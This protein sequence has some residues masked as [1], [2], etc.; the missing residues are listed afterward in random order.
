MRALL[1]PDATSWIART[2]S[3]LL[4]FLAS[5]AAAYLS[6]IFAVFVTPPLSAPALEHLV[7]VQEA[8]L[9]AP[10][11]APTSFWFELRSELEAQLIALAVIVPAWLL[12]WGLRLLMPPLIPLL[13]PLDAALV[14]LAVA[15][16]LLGYPLTLRGIRAR[17]RVVLMRRH[18]A[19]VLG[20]G[21]AF[22]LISAI[23]GAAI[24]LLPAGVV[25]ATRLAHQ[26]SSSRS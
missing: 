6:V 3:S 23:P 16:N 10:P 15:W 7:R 26:L 22:G 14:A 24:L 13:F 17:E 4:A 9:N 8:A 12:S 20:F 18:G 19:A 11:R 5:A 1:W 21:A 2:F 25:G